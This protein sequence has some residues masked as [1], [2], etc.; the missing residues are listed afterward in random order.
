M[1]V[2]ELIMTLDLTSDIPIYTQIKNAVVAKIA[3]RELPEGQAL[4]SVRQLAGDIGVNMQTVNK[5]YNMLRY[6]GYINIHR[7]K[8][9]VI[10]GNITEDENWRR[11]MERDIGIITQ[12]AVSRNMSRQAFIDMC[13]KAYG[14]SK[15]GIK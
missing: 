7:R 9:A 11:K 15:G 1:E 6:D 3:S 5:A 8:G 2:R 12:E 10:A 14:N 13:Y 4:P